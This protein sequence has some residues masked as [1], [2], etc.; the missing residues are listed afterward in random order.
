MNVRKQNVRQVGFSDENYEKI[1]LESKYNNKSSDDSDTDSE[2]GCNIE[3]F[4]TLSKEPQN[5]QDDFL[6]KRQMDVNSITIR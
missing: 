5:I 1:I 4:Q 2:H 6:K 3:V